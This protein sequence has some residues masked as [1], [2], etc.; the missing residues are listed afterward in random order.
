MPVVKIRIDGLNELKKN[1][2]QSPRIVHEELSRFVK[3][4]VNIIRPMM[5]REVPFKS[6]K[7]SQNIQSKSNGLRGE[8]GPNLSAVPYACVYNCSTKI[9]T[10]KGTVPISCIKKGDEVLTQDGRYH[11]VLATP[12]FKAISKPNLVDLEIKWRIDKNHKITLTQD[13][14]VLTKKNGSICWIKAGELKREDIVFQPIKKDYKKGK[15]KK[16]ES[17]ICRYCGLKYI[18]QGK[19]YCSLE[20]RD[21]MYRINHPQSGK[22]RCETARKNIA[23][24]NIKYL[25]EHP[26]KHPNRIMC[27]KGF[28]T[29][30]EKDVRKWL[31]LLNVE[32]KKQIKIGN[33]FVDFY[34][35]ELKIIFEA[36]GAYWH[37]DQS[38]DIQRDRK[39]IKNLDKSW[40]IIHIHFTDY[41]FSKNIKNNP[42][43]NVYYI[44]VNPSMKSYVNL[45]EFKETEIVNTKKWIHNEKSKDKLLYDLT[46]DKVHS[47]VASGIIISNSFVH[48]GTKPHEIRPTTKKALYWKGALHPVKVVRHPGTKAN[49]FVD[50]TAREAE[51]ITPR[52]LTTFINNINKRLTK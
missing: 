37:K 17:K 22:K 29:S 21:K 19:K 44:Q 11:K 6:G 10:V 26:E 43:K 18:K 15:G 24:S 42:I 2:A 51:K 27:K 1:M 14:K 34:C 35:E 33:S 30:T 39:L 4:T 40:T 49:K 5:R 9:R 13:H 50:R 28:E 8:I 20:C 16:Y 7:L 48:E 36:D 38:K 45:Q 41:R 31:D 3:T 32:Y 12:R 52:I 23:E 25:K 47:F 46:V